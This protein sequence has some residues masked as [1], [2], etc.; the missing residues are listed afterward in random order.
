MRNVT[1]LALLLVGSSAAL[2]AAEFEITPFVGY[3]WGGGVDSDNSPLFTEDV[4]IDND[5]AYGLILGL[6]PT[7][8]L[9]V[10]LSADRQE[11][12]FVID[13]NTLFGG[14]STLFDVDTTYY[15]VG[16][17]YN[18]A[19]GDGHVETFITGALGVASLNPDSPGAQTA[20]E[21]STSLGAGVKVWANPHVGFRFELR[22]Y[23]A[24][25]A[26]ADSCDVCVW[27]EFDDDLYQT[28]ARIGLVVRF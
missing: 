18:W 11:S 15:Q 19:P 6:R 1:I 16:L 13:S 7:R 28:E 17:G 3:R 24:D 12:R 20:T 2:T 23:W 4:E 10:E 5:S 14:S 27:D 22:G 26:D 8:G 9:I 25:T 21:F